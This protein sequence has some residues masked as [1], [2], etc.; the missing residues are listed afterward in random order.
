LADAI[1]AEIIPWASR[2]IGVCYTFPGNDQQFN[3]IG[4]EDR[5]TLERLERTPNRKIPMLT[6]R[7]A[8]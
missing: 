6:R 8:T 4:T 5:A 1:A 7:S 3:P 2:G